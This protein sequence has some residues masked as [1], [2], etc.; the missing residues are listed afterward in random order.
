MAKVNVRAAQLDD[1]IGISALH[2]TQVHTWQRMDAGGKVQDVL[3]EALTIYERWLHGGAWMSVETGAI[4][5][6]RLLLGAGLALV[7]VADG[8]VVGYAEGYYGHEPAP[9]GDHLNLGS[10]VV[11][12][13]VST[14]A[15]DRALTDAMLAEAKRLKSARLTVSVVLD[16]GF[17]RHFGMEVLARSQRYSIP[18]RTGQV[19]YKVSEHL[20]ADAAQI[21]QWHMPVGRVSSARQA[22]ETLWHRQWDALPEVRTRRTA[23]LHFSAAG[24]EALV[25]IQQQLYMPRSA[26]VAIWSPKPLTNPILSA[27]RDW[28][29]RENYRALLLVVGDAAAKVL[30][31]EAEA[32]GY[33]QDLYTLD[34]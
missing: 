33:Y 28:A 13:D 9:F 12:P 8:V 22:W 20:N 3:Y 30:G 19:F 32:D 31:G 29:H 6:A 16:E 14:Q 2:R 7:A 21:A 18:A 10:L 24:Q 25:H 17:Y 23:R 27:V 1:T 34:L 11:H 4:H 26:D 15:V 5:L